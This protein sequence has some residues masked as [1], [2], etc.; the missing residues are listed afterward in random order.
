MNDISPVRVGQTSPSCHWN[1]K[2]ALGNVVPMDGGTTF[3]QY[4]YNVNSGQTTQGQGSFTNFNPS[5]GTVD[6]NW[7]AADSAVAGQYQVFAGYLTP[8]GAQGYTDP[9][10]WR[11]DPITIQQ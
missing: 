3:T 11:V 6:Y 4:I 9:V 2:D 10:D 8:G 5:G 7:N 1:F